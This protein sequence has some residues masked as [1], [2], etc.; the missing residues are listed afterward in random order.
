M[1][2]ESVDIFLATR[3]LGHSPVEPLVFGARV[4]H[5]SLPVVIQVGKGIVC[6]L[7]PCF[8]RTVNP[9]RVVIHAEFEALR[10]AFRHK[11]FERDGAILRHIARRVGR[12]HGDEAVGAYHVISVRLEVRSHPVDDFVPFCRRDVDG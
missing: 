4:L 11:V 2:E 9:Q 10:L 6:S 5:S 12:E 8:T 7:N 1:L 3:I